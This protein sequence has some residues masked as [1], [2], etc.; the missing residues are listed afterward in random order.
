MDTTNLD[1]D[2]LE[3]TISQEASVNQEVLRNQEDLDT[4]NQEALVIV[5]QGSEAIQVDQVIMPRTEDSKVVVLLQQLTM[6]QHQAS[7]LQLYQ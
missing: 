4:V 5:N 7:L 6:L 1:T 3:D 2:N